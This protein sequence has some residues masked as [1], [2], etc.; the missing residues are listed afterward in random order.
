MNCAIRKNREGGWEKRVSSEGVRD[1]EKIRGRGKKK[2][3]GRRILC[4]SSDLVK[5][6]TALSLEY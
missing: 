3:E 5:P 4:A 6:R 1:G 2:R